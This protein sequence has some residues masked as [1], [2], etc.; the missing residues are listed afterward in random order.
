MSSKILLN[1]APRGPKETVK[2]VR[3]LG[4]A[5]DVL[6]PAERSR[7]ARLLFARIDPR[8]DGLNLFPHH[9]VPAALARKVAAIPSAPAILALARARSG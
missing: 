1:G 2:A 6:F 3:G 7:I 9:S 4:A 5:W 8:L